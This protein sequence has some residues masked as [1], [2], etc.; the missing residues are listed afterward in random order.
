MSMKR[1]VCL[2]SLFVIA[3]ISL[4]VWAQSKVDAFESRNAGVGTKAVPTGS[5]PML[6]NFDREEIKGSLPEGWASTGKAPFK[7]GAQNTAWCKPYSEPYYLTTSPQSGSGI[8]V[9]TP[10]VQMYAGHIYQLRF[11][12]LAPGFFLSDVV[13]ES[14][15]ITYGEDQTEAAHTYQILDMPQ[16]PNKSKKI[17]WMEVEVS[18]EAQKNGI[19]CIGINAYEA[20]SNALGIDNFELYDMEFP[21]APEPGFMSDG[22]IWATKNEGT[23]NHLRYVYPQQPIIFKNLSKYATS[24]SWETF[25]TPAVATEENPEVCYSVSGNYEVAMTAINRTAEKDYKA[26]V[27]VSVLGSQEIQ[28]QISNRGQYDVL[29]GPETVETGAYWD[30]IQGISKFSNS[31]A[32][33]IELPEYA[34]AGVEAVSLMLYDYKLA[35][36]DYHK[37]VTIKICG[38]KNGAPDMNRVLGSCQTTMAEFLGEEEILILPGEVIKGDQVARTVRFSTPVEVTGSFYIVIEVDAS[39][40][41]NASTIVGLLSLYKDN[42]KTHAYVYLG[43][44]AAQA[45]ATASGWYR[46]DKLPKKYFPDYS[47]EGLSFYL[48][49]KL[50]FH[51]IPGLGV[52]KKMCEEGVTVFPVAFK[53]ELRIES[54][55]ESLQT[56]EIFTVNGQKVYGARLSGKVLTIDTSSWSSGVYIVRAKE[57][58]SSTSIK[59]FKL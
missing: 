20:S 48:A 58:A 19:Y 29:A 56:V 22:G 33:K 50:T 31:F 2:L 46:A 55:D 35:Y 30:Y 25:G 9:F 38:E 34:K 10:G 44:E 7:V 49:P 17:E 53:D 43:D 13:R 54:K 5:L 28:A 3:V 18:F 37:P 26:N 51:V 36:P 52:E 6:E 21:P 39:V 4:S 14:I 23:K 15:K 32:E 42:L 40:K 59:V 45:L 47:L 27:N 1:I 12:L 57:S 24:Y 41:A 8:W 11:Q 16:I